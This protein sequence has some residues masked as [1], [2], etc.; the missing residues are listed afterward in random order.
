MFS[1][2]YVLYTKN[3]V[4]STMTSAMAEMD[5]TCMIYIE[6]DGREQPER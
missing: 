3:S 1:S 5:K 4:F 2:L 6:E